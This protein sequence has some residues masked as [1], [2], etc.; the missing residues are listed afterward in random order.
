M[1]V[2]IF[3]EPQ[4]GIFWYHDG[5][6]MYYS[7]PAGIAPSSDGFSDVDVSHYEYWDILRSRSPELKA[8]EYEEVPRGRVVMDAE[9][10]LFIA[11]SSGALIGDEV[12]QNELIEQFKLPRDKVRF[13]QDPHYE[14]PSTINWDD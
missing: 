2:S 8:Y 13:K 6:L 14:D 4:V 10:S 11:Y 1:Y 12:F 7:E 5:Q 9:R 3:L